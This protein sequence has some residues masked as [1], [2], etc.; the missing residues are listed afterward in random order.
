MFIC[1]NPSASVTTQ[2]GTTQ[3]APVCAAN[4]ASSLDVAAQFV[5]DQPMG[6]SVATPRRPGCRARRARG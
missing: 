4:A 5:A 1:A 3:D 2:P 6:S